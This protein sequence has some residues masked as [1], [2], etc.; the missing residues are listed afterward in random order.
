MF[1][2]CLCVQVLKELTDEFGVVIN[3]P[4]EGETV[5]VRGGVELVPQAIAKI[6]EI[7][8]DLVRP[9]QPL[10]FVNLTYPYLLF[11][12]SIGYSH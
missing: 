11:L 2:S 4:R 10:S 3:F 5:V 6:N 8:A 7:I 12:L 1:V 9:V